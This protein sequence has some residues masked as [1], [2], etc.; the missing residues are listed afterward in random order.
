MEEDKCHCRAARIE[1]VIARRAIRFRIDRLLNTQSLSVKRI[2]TQNIIT[3]F[4][5]P[6]I[7]RLLG[8]RQFSP[9]E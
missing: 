4:L 2:M 6:G 8:N 7:A 5:S 3:I 9:R 1:L